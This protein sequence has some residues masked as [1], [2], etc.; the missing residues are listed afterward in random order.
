MGGV[1]EAVFKMCIGNG[2]GFRFAE[3]LSMDELFG[4]DYGSFLLELTEELPGAQLIGTVT[5]DGLFHC[6]GEALSMDELLGL[7]EGRLEEV[8]PCNIPS[9]DMP[10]EAFSRSSDHRVAPAVQCA[11]PK[12]LIPAFPGTNCEFDSAK[13]VRDAGAEPEILVINNVFAANTRNTVS[14]LE[15]LAGG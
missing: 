10:L 7:Y 2:F 8:Y 3:C 4:W 15:R 12:V 1:A 13:A 11:R 14:N 5:D 9:P 6:G